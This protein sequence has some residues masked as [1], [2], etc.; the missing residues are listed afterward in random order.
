MRRAAKV[1]DNQAEIVR[2]L[3][4]LGASVEPALARCGSGCPDLLVGFAG[5]TYVLEVKIPGKALT[6]DE[7]K[8]HQEWRGQVAIVTT[9]QEAAAVIGAIQYPAKKAKETE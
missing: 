8:W 3:R 5:R 9:W 6:T 1:D 4:K 2:S 7:R